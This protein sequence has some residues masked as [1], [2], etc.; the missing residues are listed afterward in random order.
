MMEK[1]QS[2]RRGPDAIELTAEV[3]HIEPERAVEGFT[4]NVPAWYASLSGFACERT[5]L[6]VA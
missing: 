6:P 2:D 4:L 1:A 5:A 3:R